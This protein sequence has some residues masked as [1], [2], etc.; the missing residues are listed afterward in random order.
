MRTWPTRR[1][2]GAENGALDQSSRLRRTI[3][4]KDQLE[5]VPGASSIAAQHDG[6][7]VV[8]VDLGQKIKRMLYDRAVAL[9]RYPAVV[10]VDHDLIRPHLLQIV[11]PGIA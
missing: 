3:L 1:S 2:S 8:L 7:L 11:E 6:I 4:R 9:K 5:C 10:L